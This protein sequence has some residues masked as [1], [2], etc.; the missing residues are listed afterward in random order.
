MRI[1]KFVMG[2][3]WFRDGVSPGSED[4]ASGRF[5]PLLGAAS[6]LGPLPDFWTSSGQSSSGGGI[7]GSDDGMSSSKHPG[8]F[9]RG[10]A[11]PG[12]FLFPVSESS[13]FGTQDHVGHMT[14]SG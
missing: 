10:R 5:S 3:S 2:W 9:H 13:R 1:G 14:V 4:C 6:E 7:I 11:C 12:S 8:S